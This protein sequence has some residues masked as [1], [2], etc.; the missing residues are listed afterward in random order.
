MFNIINQKI[1]GYDN[2]EKCELL[3]EMVM[4]MGIEPLTSGL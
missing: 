3:D 2:E 1:T 4:V